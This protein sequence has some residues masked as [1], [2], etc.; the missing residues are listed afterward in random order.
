MCPYY[1]AE[2]RV[3][4]QGNAFD[5]PFESRERNGECVQ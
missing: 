3:F 5:E 1:S 4:E 2:I